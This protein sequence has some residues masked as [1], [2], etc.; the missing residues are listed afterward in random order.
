MSLSRILNEP[1]SPPP[2]PNDVGR[3]GVSPP[4]SMAGPSPVTPNDMGYGSN[5]GNG[6][7]GIGRHDQ[8][9][10]I[11]GDVGPISTNGQ[12]REG[13]SRPRKRRRNYV[14]EVDTQNPGQRRVSVLAIDNPSHL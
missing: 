4:S 2:Q 3:G 10:N 13:E 14:D 1:S 7:C 12:H 9:S 5:R 11:V 8:H 6:K